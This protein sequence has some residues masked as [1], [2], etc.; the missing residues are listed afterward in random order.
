M[1]SCVSHY[2]I[3]SIHDT[4]NNT[5]LTFIEL[6]TA[7]VQMAASRLSN[8]DRTSDHFQEKKSYI[9]ILYNYY[10]T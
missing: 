9:N 5:I 3:N 2:D 10:R 7:L 6:N 8:C 4:A 1:E